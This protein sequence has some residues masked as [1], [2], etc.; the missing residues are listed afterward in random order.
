[1][2]PLDSAR[3]SP[4]PEKHELSRVFPQ[5]VLMF[6]VN[7]EDAFR[8]PAATGWDVDLSAGAQGRRQDPKTP[9]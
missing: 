8:L 9:V 5:P 4:T 1:M 7:D 2:P 3:P 6:A